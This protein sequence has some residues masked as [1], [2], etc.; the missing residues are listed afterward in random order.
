MVFCRACG[1]ELHSTARS[2]PHCGALQSASGGFVVAAGSHP[3][4]LPTLLLCLCVGF[5]GVHRFFVG[6]WG[7][8]LLHL[9]TL[10]GL[11]IWTLID[12]I[13][14][15]TGRFRSARGELLTSSQ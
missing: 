14:I 5:L 11:G 9:F 12:L 10:G 1:K 2:C 13:L 7:T 15:A 3:D 6:K 4:W 8:G